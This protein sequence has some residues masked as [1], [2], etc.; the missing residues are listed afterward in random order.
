MK[1]EELSTNVPALGE[2]GLV[3]PPLP[4]VQLD[5]IDQTG[6]HP[7]TTIVMVDQPN[8]TAKEGSAFS[9]MV[10]QLVS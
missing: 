3:S 6:I 10:V 2:K 9:G 4:I 1:V 7:D 8:A 5:A